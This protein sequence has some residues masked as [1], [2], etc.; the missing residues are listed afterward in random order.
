MKSICF[1]LSWT[2]I[3]IFIAYQASVIA[4]NLSGGDDFYCEE[5][6]SADRDLPAV[7]AVGDIGAVRDCLARYRN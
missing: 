4:L 5:I 1:V 2:F 7:V 3:A 6:S